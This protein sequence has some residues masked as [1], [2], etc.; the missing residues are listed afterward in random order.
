MPGQQFDLYQLV[1]EEN[2]VAKA[3]NG[4]GVRPGVQPSGSH[5]LPRVSS[6]DRRWN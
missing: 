3:W 2:A 1:I 5:T 6:L 4:T